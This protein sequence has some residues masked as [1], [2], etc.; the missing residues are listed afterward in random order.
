MILFRVSSGRQ[1]SASQRPVQRFD[2]TGSETEP[3]DG[4]PEFCESPSY[5]NIRREE[6]DFSHGVTF[7]RFCCV[8]L[9]NAF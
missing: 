7:T 4:F 8:F 9:L 6:A 1:C 5:K 3:V 2:D